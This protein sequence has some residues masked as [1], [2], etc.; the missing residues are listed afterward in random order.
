M[1]ANNY[2]ID[3]A[4]STAKFWVRHLG[5]SKVHGTLTGVT[6]TATYD[7][8]APETTTADAVVDINTISTGQPDRDGHLKSADFFDVA[9]YPTMTF[10]TTSVTKT[11][12]GEYKVVGDLTLHGVT[13]SVTFDGE[14]SD[15]MK[16]P[17]GGYKVGITLAGK[18]VR[19]DFGLVWNQAL[20]TG[21]FMIGKEV[22]LELDLEI[23]RPE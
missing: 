9:T 3:S 21:G 6:G 2:T 19:D 5:I 12:E 20:E 15:E 7:P 16:S 1:S 8:A 23:D 13:K 18:I 17:F 4:H 11:G 22:H 10:K 14:V